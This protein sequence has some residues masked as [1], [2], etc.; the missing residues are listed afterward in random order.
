MTAC[1]HDLIQYLCH[2]YCKHDTAVDPA[3]AVL[4]NIFRNSNAYVWVNI[5]GTFIEFFISPHLYT[6]V[7]G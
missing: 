5:T 4:R 2:D 1:W 3:F 7:V 6:Q